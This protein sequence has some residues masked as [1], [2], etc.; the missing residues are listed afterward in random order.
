MTCV[1]KEADLKFDDKTS[2]LSNIVT[3]IPFLIKFKPIHT[4]W[5]PDPTIPTDL[6]LYFS[7]GN[8]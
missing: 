4:P 1:S 2:V 5:I 6:H 7:I 8:L 3:G